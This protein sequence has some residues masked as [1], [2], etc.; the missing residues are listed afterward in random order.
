MANI[1]LV[2]DDR[3]DS[4]LASPALQIQRVPWSFDVRWI[5]PTLLAS[6]LVVVLTLLGW[7]AAAVWR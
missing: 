7:P 1:A 2:D 6:L 4:Y 5:A 3:S